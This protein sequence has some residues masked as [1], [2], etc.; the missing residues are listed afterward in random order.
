MNTPFALELVDVSKSYGRLKALNKVSLDIKPAQFV[1]LLGQNGAGKST[2]FQLLTG[3]FNSDE[4]QLRV[5]GHDISRDPIKALSS[6][7]VVF[8][9][10][11]LDLDLTVGGNLKFHCLLHGLSRKQAD[12]RI[13]SE[14]ERFSMQE[15]RN[16]VV[17][18]LSGGNRRKV[19]L[20]RALLHEPKVLLM[21]EATVGLDP[22]SRKSLVN[23]VLTLCK[24]REIAVLWSTHII[25]EVQ[26]AD[27]VIV[28]DKGTILAESSPEQLQMESEKPSLTLADAFSQLIDKNKNIGVV[29]E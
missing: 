3:L 5:C 16:T 12:L 10:S 14:L 24:E 28:L 27:S 19:E 23:H 1:G 29:Y 25:E 17:R 26:A 22:E 15:I 21:D 2:L 7:G 9:Q 20:I 8:Q 18:N 13:D 6:L 11:T 4:G